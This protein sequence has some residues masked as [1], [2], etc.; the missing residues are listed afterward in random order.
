[1]KT[2]GENIKEKRQAL[3]LS[4]KKLAEKVGVCQQYLCRLEKDQ[5]VPSIIMA[6]DIADALGCSLDELAGREVEL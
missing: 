1:M 6:A 5:N 2:I 3:G 4:Q